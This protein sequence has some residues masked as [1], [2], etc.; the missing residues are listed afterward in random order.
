MS[1]QT[2]TAYEAGPLATVRGRISG[3]TNFANTITA[4]T[5]LG[6]GVNWDFGTTPGTYSG[7]LQWTLAPY[8]SANVPDLVPGI[9][10]PE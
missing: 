6:Y 1:G 2:W 8:V 10:Q 9:G 4:S 5:D 3:G 7:T